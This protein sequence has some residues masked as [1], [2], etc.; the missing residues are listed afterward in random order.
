M[1][2]QYSESSARLRLK[3][4]GIATDGKTIE[5][6]E[7]RPAGIRLFGAIDFLCRYCGYC[8]RKIR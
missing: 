5:I 2:M 3:N 4:N 6:P 7:K 1:A 8:W